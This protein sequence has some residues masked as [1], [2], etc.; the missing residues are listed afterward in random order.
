MDNAQLILEDGT[1][2]KGKS[3]GKKGV[4][5]GELNFNTAHVGYQE[6][7]TDPSWAGQL[8]VF[9]TPHIGNVG[10][11]A[12]DE[13]SSHFWASGIIVREKPTHSNYWRSCLTLQDYLERHQVVGIAEIDTRALTKLLRT[14]GH[15]SAAIVSDNSD[16]KQAQQ[17]ARE[18]NEVRCSK[19]LEK[20]SCKSSYQF[21]N[22]LSTLHIV[23]YDF[24][25][26]KNI[27]KLLSEQD[28]RITVVP[29]TT[30]F[31]QV[32]IL[33]PDGIV[34]SNGPG[35]PFS[36]TEV[37]EIVGLLV[38]SAVP[39]FGICLGNQLL[40][41]SLGAQLEKLKFGHHGINHPI[42]DLDTGKIFISSQ[43]HNFVISEKKLPEDILVTYRS[44]FDYSIQGIRHKEKPIFGIQGHPEGCP[45]P[46]DISSCFEHFLLMAKRLK[47]CQSTLG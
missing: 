18:F 19:L 10:C 21:S 28:C 37:I 27:L 4:A 43:N 41:I 42:K 44:L 16:L 33:K 1:L 22:K 7:F 20:V 34:L 6:A 12:E 15:Y 24:G 30:P 29:A 25:V 38:Q 5:V 11:N 23:V 39:I 14:K 2:F 13:E 8:I 35:D 9:T 45:G 31:A 32:E 17:R 3:I 47:E 26:K 36:Y 40:G 46:T